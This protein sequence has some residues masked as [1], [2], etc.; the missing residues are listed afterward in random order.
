MRE[1]KNIKP[2]TL[3][4]TR[5]FNNQSTVLSHMVIGSHFSLTGYTYGVLIITI[6]RRM[7]V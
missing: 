4:E 2:R 3:F 7:I 1:A 6:Y 5:G